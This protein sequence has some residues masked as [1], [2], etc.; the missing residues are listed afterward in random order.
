MNNFDT[1]FKTIESLT[2]RQLVSLHCESKGYVFKS[3]SN[4]WEKLNFEFVNSHA[5]LGTENRSL[6]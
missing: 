3:I 5:N 1:I 6:L 4:G 2:G